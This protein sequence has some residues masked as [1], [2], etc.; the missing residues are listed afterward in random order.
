[1]GVLKYNDIFMAVYICVN[2]GYILYKL[3]LFPFYKK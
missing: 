3:A 1:M 2:Q